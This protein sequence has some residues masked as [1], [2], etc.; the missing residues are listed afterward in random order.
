MQDFYAN[1]ERINKMSK[2]VLQVLEEALED[3]KFHWTR[4]CLEDA[5]NDRRCALGAIN[6]AVC[7]TAISPTIYLAKNKASIYID[8]V[9]AAIPY[10]LREE[11]EKDIIS[12]TLVT[13]VVILSGINDKFGQDVIV[14]MFQR[15]IRFEKSRLAREQGEVVEITEQEKEYANA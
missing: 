8:A 13:P 5:T 10:D 6:K 12:Y 11:I 3:V 9:L 4:G 14:D 15:A 7:G 2:P 1:L